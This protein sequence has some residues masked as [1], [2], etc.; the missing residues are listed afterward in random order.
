MPPAA[1]EPAIS[2]SNRRPLGTAFDPRTF[3]PVASRY[4]DCAMAA[5]SIPKTPAL[6]AQGQV[7]VWSF[8]AVLCSFGKKFTVL[9]SEE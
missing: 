1:F 4:T 7:L 8:L 6:I 3:Q 2:A 9:D 5:Y